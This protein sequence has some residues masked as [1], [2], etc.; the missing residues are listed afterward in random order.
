MI[1]KLTIKPPHILQ[2]EY[3]ICGLL[4]VR[5]ADP[6]DL[7]VAIVRGSQFKCKVSSLSRR[8]AEKRL[9]KKVRFEEDQSE[10]MNDFIVEDKGMKTTLSPILARPVKPVASELALVSEDSERLDA[11]LE[12]NH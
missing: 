3:F 8:W 2:L 4:E 11:H 9:K 10:D 7:D 1:G 6:Y 5:K 12:N